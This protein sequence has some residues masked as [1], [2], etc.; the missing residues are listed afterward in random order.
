MPAGGAW[1]TFNPYTYQQQHS[2]GRGWGSNVYRGG[3]GSSQQQG[4]Y[5]QPPMP[6]AGAGAWGQPQQ[7]QGQW[8]QQPQ[9]PPQRRGGGIGGGIGGRGIGGR[10]GGYGGSQGFG[11][12]GETASMFDK[13]NQMSQM[14]QMMGQIYG[15]DPSFQQ[16]FAQASMPF[17][18]SKYSGAFPVMDV[19]SQMGMR[20]PDPF[21]S[22]YFGGGG[23]PV[24]GNNPWMGGF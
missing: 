10:G 14:Q 11:R 23:Q 6:Y 8:G 20:E 21:S 3:Q 13:M 5:Q 17:M 12:Q 16:S 7:S 18:H 15:H 24:G 19:F 4:G 22:V 2:T 9:Q 1:G